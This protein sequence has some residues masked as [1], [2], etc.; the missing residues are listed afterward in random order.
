VSSPGAEATPRSLQGYFR[1]F[2]NNVS[3]AVGTPWAFLVALGA[4][5]VW[6]LTGPF[7]HFSETWQLT[8]NTACSIIPTLMVFLIQNMQNRDAKAMHLKLDELIR[9]SAQARN[10]LIQ[11]EAMSDAEL[12]ALEQEFRK[13]RSNRQ[14]E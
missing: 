9:A 12:D 6:A 11:L 5:L 3:E 13:L 14:G 8:I 1:V 10:Q 7:F 4:V 2:A